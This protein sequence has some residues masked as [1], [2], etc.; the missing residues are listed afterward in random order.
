MNFFECTY[1]GEPSKIGRFGKL[2][3]GDSVKLTKEEYDCVAEDTRFTFQGE[4][5]EAGQPVNE[6]LKEVAP[7][8]ASKKPAR[9]K[10]QAS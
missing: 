9:K 6:A 8:P 4:V 3:K 1:N 7:K 2:N 5:D 10:K